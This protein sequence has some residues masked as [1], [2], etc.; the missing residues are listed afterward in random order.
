MIA[1][2]VLLT[3]CD[4]VKG[5]FGKNSGKLATQAAQIT[6]VESKQKIIEVKKVG[7]VSD[8]SY[9]VGYSL[10]K[11]TNAS[12]PVA[13]AKELNDRVQSIVGLPDL[14]RQKQMAILVDNLIVENIE[15]KQ[16]LKA[17][18]AE[19]GAIQREAKL[20]VVQKEKAVSDTLE[21]SKQIAMKADSTQAELDKY[22]GWFGLSAV[23]IGL[24]QFVT[25]SFWTLLGLGIAFLILRVLSTINPIAGAIFSIIDVVLSWFINIIKVLAPKAIAISGHVA[26]E[27]YTAAKSTLGKVVDSVETA[28]LQA[29]A[30]GNS[31]TIEE[32]LDIA[33]QSMTPEDKALIDKL[34]IEMN[35][36]KP[37]TKSTVPVMKPVPATQ[38]TSLP[39]GSTDILA[40][41]LTQPLGTLVVS[42][43][44]LKG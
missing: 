24:K 16:Q 6:S 18:D 28:K 32:L 33:S 38:P 13:V 17:K 36:V 9:G 27:A 25:T 5:I 2:S 26:T 19:I 22:K 8:L 39:T 44:L 41:P 10:N 20:L 1:V 21:L 42:S 3:S 23:W 4:T 43:S 12:M 15:G 35:W 31:T 30:S 11:D 40:A 37:S 34:K 14:E 7:E 29:A